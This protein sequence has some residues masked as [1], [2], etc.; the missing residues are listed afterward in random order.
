[1]SRTLLRAGVLLGTTALVA[2]ASAAPAFAHVTANGTV[3]KGGYGVVTFRVPNEDDTA[4]TVAVTVNLPARPP[5]QLG[6][7]HPD[8]RLD[9]HPQR[10]HAQPAAQGR[11]RQRDHE[12]RRLGH[13]Q[14]QPGHPD[15]AGPVHGLPA[16]AR[17]V[18]GQRRRPPMPAAQTY[19]NGK[20]VNWADPPNADGS[21]PEHPAPS[22]TLTAATG[23]HHGGMATAAARPSRPRRGHHRPLA[24]RRGPARRRAGPGLRRGRGAADPASGEVGLMR[25]VVALVLRGGGGA[26]PRRRARVGAQP[27]RREQPGRRGQRRHAA[28]RRFAHVQ[29]G[30][31]GRVHGDHADR[32]GRQ[33][34]PPRRRDRD[35]PD[36]HGRR[37]AARARRDATRSGTGWCPR[38]GTRC[39]ARRRSR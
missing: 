3:Q 10:G 26:A 19:D 22:V 13:V 38:T 20:V 8:R 6:A 31:P 34:L 11:R 16:L 25:R 33:G 14:G 7:H 12:D 23:D 15:R 18:P 21:E 39:R 5:L 9:R 36:G 17:P 27:A 28:P 29:R 2:L 30:R 1:M 37:V 24:G 35:R 32:P 4:G